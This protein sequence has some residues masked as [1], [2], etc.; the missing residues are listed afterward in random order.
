MD[1]KFYLELSL[2]PGELDPQLVADYLERVAGILYNEH[3]DFVVGDRYV[4]R[5]YY[6]KPMGSWMV[7]EDD[8]N[9]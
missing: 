5:S 6:G 3:E 4:I 9:G 7:R 2:D 1:Q 8:D